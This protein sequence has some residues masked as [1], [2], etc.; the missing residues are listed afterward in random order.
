MPLTTICKF[1]PLVFLLF[2]CSINSASF[3]SKPVAY[4]T[5]TPSKNIAVTHFSYTVSPPESP[6][7]HSAYADDY[8]VA[9]EDGVQHE[10]LYSKDAKRAMDAINVAKAATDLYRDIQQSV[11]KMQRAEPQ[12]MP[13]D[14]TTDRDSSA[15]STSAAQEGYRQVYAM[16]EKRVQEEL[17]L[18]LLPIDSARGFAPYDENGFPYSPIDGRILP[19]N[20]DAALAVAIEVNYRS[21]TSREFTNEAQVVWQPEIAVY[22]EMEDK[23]NKT[24]WADR[25]EHKTVAKLTHYYQRDQ[26]EQMQL[27]RTAGPDISREIETA[28]GK[29]HL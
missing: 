27:V 24:L 6:Y 28:L 7:A 12:A 18:P 21:R 25:I 29:I 5:P 1:L 4:H 19:H 10:V 23:T 14:D 16:L 20:I 2:G 13:V 11:P 17:G 22:L 15:T 26:Y 3:S 9:I 8:V